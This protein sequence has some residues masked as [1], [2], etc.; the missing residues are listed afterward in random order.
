M[1]NIL[2]IAAGG[3]VG[4]SLRYLAGLMSMKLFGKNNILTGTVFANIAG[5]FCAGLILAMIFETDDI[6]NSPA[7]LFFSIGLIGSLSTF[8]TFIL[9]LVALLNEKSYSQLTAYLFLQL[10]VVFTATM[11]GFFIYK[12]LFG[13]F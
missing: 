13:G 5:C 10:F 11:S 9:E 12:E 1:Q 2:L 7:Y 3:A 6:M 4:A 8:S